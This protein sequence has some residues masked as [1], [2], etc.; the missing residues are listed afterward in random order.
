MAII[1]AAEPEISNFILHTFFFLVKISQNATLINSANPQI[2]FPFSATPD[3]DSRRFIRPH[4]A[5]SGATRGFTQR[6][7]VSPE[8][9]KWADV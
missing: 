6:R 4:T 1:D 7:N 2:S 8:T 5:P 9:C 3:A